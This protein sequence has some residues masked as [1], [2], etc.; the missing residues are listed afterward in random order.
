[1]RWY[2]VFLILVMLMME[3]FLAEPVGFCADNSPVT[4]QDDDI[5]STIPYLAQHSDDENAIEHQFKE[6][7]QE[8]RVALLIGNG[9]YH[10]APLKNPMNDVRVMAKTLENLGFQI[11]KAENASQNRMKRLIDEFGRRI[12]DG[13]VGLF[14]YA[15][16]GMQVAGRNYLIPVGSVIDTEND[17]EYE[18]V[19]MGRVLAKMKDARNRLNIAILDACRNNPFKQRFRGGTRGLATVDAPRGTFIVY[20]TAPGSVAVDGDGENSVF[21]EALVNT[22]QI[23]GL[24]IEDA[25]KR[26]RAAVRVNTKGLQI[27]WQSSSL[28]GD[29]YFALPKKS[30]KKIPKHRVLPTF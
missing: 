29:F 9:D 16:H 5:L 4:L 19:D 1:M 15:G 11:M 20:A 22:V 26:I 21:T 8:K 6:M 23:E 7:A 12:Q 28:E 27:P 2:G 17:V 25:F 13:G 14:F 18:S 10:F 24:K 3:L 30:A